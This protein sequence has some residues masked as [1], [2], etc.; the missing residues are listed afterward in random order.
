MPH[1]IAAVS[2]RLN[3]P[4]D[5]P[6]SKRNFYRAE[7]YFLRFRVFSLPNTIFPRCEELSFSLR[8]G[9]DAIRCY[10]DLY[11]RG[12]AWGHPG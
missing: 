11:L 8:R 3:A 7:T 6:A 12:Q 1:A 9:V 2:V 5:F 4:Q 10:T